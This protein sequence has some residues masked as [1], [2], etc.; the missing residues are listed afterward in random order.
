VST[1]LAPLEAALDR[2]VDPCS[3][4][5]GA[6]IGL[7]EMGL[8]TGL[9]LDGGHARV[10]LSLTSPMC[11]QMTNIVDMVKQEL[12]ALEG[13]TWVS[14]EIDPAADWMPDRM[15]AGAKTRLRAVRPLPIAPVAIS[16][17]GNS[18]GVRIRS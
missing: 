16:P 11:W 17:S 10:T 6:P 15:S 1:D 9:T 5:T 3:I 2:V 13:V 14:C 8:V 18:E 7:R 4:A 12:G